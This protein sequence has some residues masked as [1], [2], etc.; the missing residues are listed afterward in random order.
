MVLETPLVISMGSRHVCGTRTKAAQRVILIH[1]G[2]GTGINMMANAKG[3]AHVD[4]LPLA[5]G[6]VK[7]DWQT[8]RCFSPTLRN[9]GQVQEAGVL[10]CCAGSIVRNRVIVK[11]ANERIT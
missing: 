2:S 3:R 9:G 8:V 6:L 4:V 10:R 7:R 5:R 1:T 11:A